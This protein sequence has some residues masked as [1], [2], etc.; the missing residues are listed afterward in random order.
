M[1]LSLVVSES[2][3]GSR[4]MYC[5]K[6]DPDLGKEPAF[7]LVQGLSFC[8]GPYVACLR[9]FSASYTLWKLRG[10]LYSLFAHSVITIK[11]HLSQKTVEMFGSF[12]LE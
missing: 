1:R 7:S 12:I 5:C 2:G 3:G 9:W 11:V 6:F 10:R 8:Y 4:T